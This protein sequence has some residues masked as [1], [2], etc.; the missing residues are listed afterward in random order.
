MQLALPP[1]P[2]PKLLPGDIETVTSASIGIRRRSRWLSGFM[3]T[4]AT[5]G[6]STAS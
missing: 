5:S 4:V 1:A 6:T 2:E 3:L